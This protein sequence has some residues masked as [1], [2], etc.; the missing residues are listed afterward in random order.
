MRRYRF[1]EI[2]NS[3]RKNVTTHFDIAIE[4]TSLPALKATKARLLKPLWRFHLSPSRTIQ[5]IA[6]EF[7]WTA[8]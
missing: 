3:L 6:L 2:S 1:F 5:L 4:I 7:F 8:I